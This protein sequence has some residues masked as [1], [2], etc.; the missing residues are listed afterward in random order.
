MS[1]LSSFIPVMFHVLLNMH[2]QE[3]FDTAANAI[4]IYGYQLRSQNACT[5]WHVQAGCLDRQV[6]FVKDVVYM[7]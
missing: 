1:W 5:I 4:N 7:H 2:K 6:M 3:G